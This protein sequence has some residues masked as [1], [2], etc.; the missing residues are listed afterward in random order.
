[1]ATY[2]GEA[3]RIYV[4][5]DLVQQATSTLSDPGGTDAVFGEAVQ[6]NG[7]RNYLVGQLAHVAVYGRALSAG[8]IASHRE[9]MF[10]PEAL[11]KRYVP[12]LR[13]DEQ[14]AYF[15]DSAATITD[16]DGGALQYSNRLLKSDGTVIASSD[17]D[18][19]GETL[20]LDFLAPT[21]PEPVGYAASATDYIDENNDT[22]EM[23]A[24]EFHNDPQY[25]NR[26]YGRAVPLADGTMLQYWAFYYN[27]PKTFFTGGDHEG[28][29]EMIQ[30]RLDENNSPVGA[31]YA[32][33]TAGE[34]CAW[35]DVERTERDRPVVY[36]AEGSHAS[37]FTAGD[38]PIPPYGVWDYANGAG[39]HMNPLLIDVT[40]VPAWMQWPGRWGGA[41]S[42]PFGPP[43]QLGSKWANPESFETSTGSC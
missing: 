10:T 40:A 23:D 37:Y 33:H 24:W 39:E 4:D 35:N 42:S 2:D 19:E 41:D 32:Q 38:H 31:T 17:P 15:P 11:L 26:I 22:R 8:E 36:V 9:I 3:M 28:D 34:Y 27:N 30:I 16:N 1:M 43:Q 21:Y 13:L 7:Y 25:R 29:W 12:E 6:S 14:E 20:S 5:G 18:L